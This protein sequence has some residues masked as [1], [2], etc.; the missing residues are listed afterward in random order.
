M[1]LLKTPAPC[2]HDAFAEAT[3]CVLLEKGHSPRLDPQKKIC[4]R[5]RTQVC[6][7]LVFFLFFRLLL[8]TL[9]KIS[10]VKLS[11][12]SAAIAEG[13]SGKYGSLACCFRLI[14]PNFD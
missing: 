1:D 3:N 9:A 6:F 7:F 13:E 2:A 10:K 5:L 8:E 14:R 12:R 11:P 4:Q